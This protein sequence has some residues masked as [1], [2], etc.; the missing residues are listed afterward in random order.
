MY[1]VDGIAY[2]GNAKTPVKVRSVKPL[3]NYRLWIRFNDGE[4]KIFDFT[5]LLDTKAF[6]PLRDKD[7]FA[8][9]YVDYGVPVWR[10]GEIDIAPETL[11]ENGIAVRC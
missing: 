5:Y 7:V 1:T 10:D 11:Y 8:S 2:A 9:V 6:L 3:D 4:T